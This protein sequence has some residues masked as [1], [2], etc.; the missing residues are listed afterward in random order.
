[1]SELPR[2]PLLRKMHWL[3]DE[4]VSAMVTPPF[5]R[6]ISMDVSELAIAQMGAR[7][8]EHAIERL[9]ETLPSLYAGDIQRTVDAFLCDRAWAEPIIRA[10][11]ERCVREF[12][13]ELFTEDDTKSR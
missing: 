13:R 12:A 9:G 10:E 4:D 2:V 3:G 8:V 6:R 11:L 7:V 5:A 1:M